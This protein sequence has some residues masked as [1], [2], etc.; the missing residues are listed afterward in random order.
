MDFDPQRKRS[1]ISDSGR[2]C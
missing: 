1:F 2:L